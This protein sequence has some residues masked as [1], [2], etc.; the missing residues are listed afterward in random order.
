MER[1]TFWDFPGYAKYDELMDDNSD[2]YLLE[3]ALK[4]PLTEAE[5]SGHCEYILYSEMGEALLFRPK[6]FVSRLAME[7]YINMLTVIRRS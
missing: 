6:K 1:K 3:P 5:R 7:L 2:N 4:D